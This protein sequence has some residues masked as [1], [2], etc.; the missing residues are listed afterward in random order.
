[1]KKSIT[2]KRML[3]HFL[4]NFFMPFNEW[5]S[6]KPI[7]VTKIPDTVASP[8]AKL[9]MYSILHMGVVPNPT[10]NK[11]PKIIIMVSRYSNLK[12]TF[13]FKSTIWNV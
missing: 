7:A 2:I 4:G 3:I 10:A 13:F 9:G 5:P 1:M 12:G 11:I 8:V 6:Q